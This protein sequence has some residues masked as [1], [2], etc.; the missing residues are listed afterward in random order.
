MF[1]LVTKG[2]FAGFGVAEL[3]ICGAAIFG[4]FSMVSAEGGPEKAAELTATEVSP[5][6]TPQKALVALANMVRPFR[7]SPNER[8]YDTTP[9]MR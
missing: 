4:V 6:S 5:T 2:Q 7:V 9:I 1:A 8:C 3:Q